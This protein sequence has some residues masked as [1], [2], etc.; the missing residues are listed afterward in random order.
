[1]LKRANKLGIELQ[2]TGQVRV[3]RPMNITCKVLS[4]RWQKDCSGDMWW[5]MNAANNRE[6]SQIAKVLG[7]SRDAVAIYAAA[8]KKRGLIEVERSSGA[9]TNR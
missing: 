4:L 6:Y 1:M 7:W 8:A 5:F 9:I 2:G 3:R